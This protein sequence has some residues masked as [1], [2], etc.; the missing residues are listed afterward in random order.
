MKALRI[1]ISRKMQFPISDGQFDIHP[2][3]WWIIRF[4]IIF[5]WW[6]VSIS[7]R[8]LTITFVPEKISCQNIEIWYRL[9]YFMWPQWVIFWRHF[10]YAKIYYWEFNSKSLIRNSIVIKSLLGISIRLAIEFNIKA[11]Q[12]SFHFNLK[13]DFNRIFNCKFLNPKP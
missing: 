7:C 10:P 2:N 3:C 4:S 12:V 6:S 13:F 1:R 11:I 8:L 9:N 5:S